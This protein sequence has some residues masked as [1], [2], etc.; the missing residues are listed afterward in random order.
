MKLRIDKILEEK[1]MSVA[2]LGRLINVSRSSIHNTITKDN[3]TIDTLERIAE[4]LK[5][6]ITD[7]FNISSENNDL[8]ALV[9]HRGRLYKASNIEELQ[10]IIEEI[11]SI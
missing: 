11:K 1:G 5:V 6:P 10:K 9:D 2:E 4:A 7:L 8:T 3:P